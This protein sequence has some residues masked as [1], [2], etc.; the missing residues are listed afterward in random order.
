MSAGVPD[1]FDPR[2]FAQG[3]PH[4]ALRLL[5]DTASVSWQDEHEVGI[6]PSGPGFWAVT[7]YADVRQV[8]AF[9]TGFLALGPA[10]LDGEPRRLTSTFIN[11]LT[12]LPLRW[13]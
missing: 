10:T 4:D 7:R 13:P 5:R 11:G 8:R 6:W 3:V 9:F 12:S 2:V 1:V